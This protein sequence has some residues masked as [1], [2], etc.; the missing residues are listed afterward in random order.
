MSEA[1]TRLKAVIWTVSLG[2]LT[3]FTLGSTITV[4]TPENEALVTGIALI[5]S[6]L[7]LYPLIV[8]NWSRWSRE[9]PLVRIVVY[10]SPLF[11]GAVVL[12]TFVSLLVGWQGLLT[13]TLD[14][15]AASLAFAVALWLSFYGGADLV[16]EYVVRKLDV[17]W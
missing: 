3:S 12:D 13:T 7:I 1:P 15:V 16:R 17:E 11:F 6:S 2:I 10:F 5:V 4:A 14:T 8:R 9:Q